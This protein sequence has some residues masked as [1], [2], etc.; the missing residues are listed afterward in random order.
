MWREESNEPD[1]EQL[2]RSRARLG[3]VVKKGRVQLQ[4]QET[5]FDWVSTGDIKLGSMKMS[6]SVP[7]KKWRP[8]VSG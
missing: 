8:F 5:V 2:K 3:S 6:C 4:R 7:G 1:G